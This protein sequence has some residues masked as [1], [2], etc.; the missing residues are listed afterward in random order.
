MISIQEIFKTLEKK[1]YSAFFF[2]P[3]IYENSKSYLF[4]KPEKIIKINSSNYDKNFKKIYELVKDFY[5]YSVINYEA[6]FLFEQKLFQLLPTN[7][8]LGE[9]VFFDKTNIEIIK[10]DKISFDFSSDYKIKNFHLNTSK[11]EYIKSI[12][13]IK[14]FIKEGDTYQVNYTVKGKFNFSGNLCSL[15]QNL[16][17]NQ[18]AKYIAF[19]NLPER[20][21]ISISPELFF[22]F[23]KNK[24]I[25]RP[26]KGTS[27]RGID[28]QNDFFAKQ[29]FSNSEK[30]KAENV[31]IVDLLRNDLGRISKFGSVKVDKLFEI[32]KYESL[33]QMTSEI[34]STPLR[35][36]KFSDII[37]KMFPCGSVTGA[38]KIRTMEIIHL[39]EKERRNIYTGSIGLLLRNKITMNVAIRTLSIDK[40][41]GKGEIGLGSGVVWDSEPEK[42]FNEVLL[43]SK[44]LTSPQSPFEIFESMLV[45]N[46]EVSFLDEHINR[47]KATADFFLFKFDEKSFR[48]ELEIFLKK[49]KRIDSLKLKIMLNKYGLI[50]FKVSELN[51]PVEKI[52]V[53]LSKSRINSQNKF[54]YFKTTNR[55]LYDKEY[56]FYSSK[57]FYEVLYL[58]EKSH[59]AEGSITNIFIRKGLNYFTPTLSS[60]ILPGIYRTFM[61]K[62]NPEI[63]EKN[64]SLHDLLNADEIILTNS[65]RG[66]VKV[67]ELYLNER[68]YISFN[69]KQIL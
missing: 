31:M 38:P 34:S 48:K 33:Y 57:E 4:S 17:F 53:I 67:D 40:K 9:F 12:Q 2:T 36:T 56:E 30:D 41:T 58:N 64:I 55:K 29:N 21:I 54:Q 65:V 19:I 66:E 3:P 37:Q 11:Q 8:T 51:I 60:G 27:H 7:K 61:M 26:M 24:I 25:T 13:K 18:S 6:G 43:K 68:E 39:I 47:L 44:F 45:R 16:I 59:L 35:G 14:D 32:E 42:E 15:F 10:S 1:K 63:K 52:R 22:E 28:T 50:S 69:K 23:N 62:K 20:F 49:L 5:A 46:S